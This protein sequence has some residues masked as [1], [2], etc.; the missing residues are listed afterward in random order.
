MPTP[1]LNKYAGT[2][3]T[4]AESYNLAFAVFHDCY[5]ERLPRDKVRL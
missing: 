5:L 4:A 1:F 3:S 2:H